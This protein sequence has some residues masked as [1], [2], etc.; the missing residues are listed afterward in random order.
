[1]T[2]PPAPTAVPDTRPPSPWRQRLGPAAVWAGL[3]AA[4]AYVL[5]FNPT[6]TNPDLSG[7]CLFHLAFGINGPF[8][9]GTR[10]WWYLVHG[11]L[12]H[13]FQHHPIALIGVPFALYALAWWTAR[14]WLG[15]IFPAPRLP[16]SV[17][18]GYATAWVVFALVLRNLSEGP[19]TWFN[20][21][22]L[23]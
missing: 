17:Y 22:Y 14:T 7:P 15:R 2:H 1:M 18:I 23:G 5:A 20:I 16:R 13:A 6:D 9:G 3:V 21:P 19:F 8:C 10:M 11:D 4:T 12:V